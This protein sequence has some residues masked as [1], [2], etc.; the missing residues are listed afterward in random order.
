MEL[1]TLWGYFEEYEL[2]YLLSDKF[3]FSPAEKELLRLWD[4]EESEAIDKKN[5][6]MS[7]HYCGH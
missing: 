7:Q 1:E 2:S 3:S 6:T 5:F 4:K